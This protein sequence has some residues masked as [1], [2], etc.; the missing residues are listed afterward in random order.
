MNT[1]K[2]SRKKF[3]LPI[4]VLSKKFRGKFLHHL[5]RE[6]LRFFGDST[7]LNDV[8]NLS[9]LLARLYKID[10]VLYCKP[11]FGGPQKVMDYQGRYTHRVAISNNRILG[12]KDG[13]VS[14]KWRDYNDGSKQKIMSIEAIEFMRRFLLHILPSGFRKI[15]HFGIFA[16]RN[17]NMRLTLCRRLTRTRFVIKPETQDERLSRIFGPG[18][19]LCPKCKSGHLSREPPLPATA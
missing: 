4:K 10:W 12:E 6:N 9:A 7:H 18:W 14:F 15:R 13:N 3:F 8:S 17:K 2:A 1:W 19:N 5:R 16:S 11:P